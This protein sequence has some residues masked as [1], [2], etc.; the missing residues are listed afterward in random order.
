MSWVRLD[1]AILHRPSTHTPTNALLDAVMVVNS[2][3]LGRKYRTNRV[4]NPGPV[5]CESM[6]LSVRPQRLPLTIIYQCITIR[7]KYAHSSVDIENLRYTN[8]QNCILLI[9]KCETK[10]FRADFFAPPPPS[11]IRSYGLEVRK[12]NERCVFRY[13]L[14]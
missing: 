11:Q 2:R 5:V 7:L 6:T 1:R 14:E 10:K 4:L 8:V 13:I 3:K 9:F 12:L